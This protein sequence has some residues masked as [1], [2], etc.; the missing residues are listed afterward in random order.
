VTG[1]CVLITGAGGFIGQHLVRDQ[2]A[3]G[4]RVRAL[5]WRR[6]SLQG[7]WPLD[8]E[9]LVG[10]AADPA[11]QREAVAGVDVVFHLASAHLERHLGDADF[12]RV[13]VGA[14]EG[15]LEHSRR[16]GVR[17]FVHV[18]S[19]GV[20]GAIEHPPADEEAPLHP[21][22]A[23]ERTKLAGELVAREFWR[24]HGLPVVVVRPVWVYG[25]GC[26]RTAR[27]FK[28]VASR[29]F[30]MVGRGSNRRSALYITDMLDA[31][32]RCA[33]RAGIEGEIFIVGHEEL[34][35]VS[36]L[37]SEIA[38]LAGVRGPRLHVPVRLASATVSL[39][40]VAGRRLGRTP[41][42]SRRSL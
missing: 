22:I 21:D 30:I 33:T 23:Y 42:L 15:L 3:R 13:N 4:R 28:A 34:V 40:E 6:E 16:A 14:V 11:V 27:L 18:S 8:L 36:R 5:D 20:H 29:R 32:E 9:L 17:R 26:R 19:S 2:L 35:T 1:S 39:L 37:V 41:S 31:L 25:P 10:D 38:R 12:Q 7:I 24:R